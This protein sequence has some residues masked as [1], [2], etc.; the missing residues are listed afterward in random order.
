V[1]Y[2]YCPP[3]QLHRTLETKRVEGL[4][5]AGQINGTSGYEEAAAQGLVAGVNAARKLRGDDEWV[6]RRDQAYI[7]VLIDDLVV[8]GTPEPYRMFTSR[9]E[10][11]LLLRQDNADER[12]TP[13]ALEAGLACSERRALFQQKQQDRTALREHCETARD[14]GL[15]LGQW[16]LRPENTWRALPAEL[17]GDFAE[18]LWQAEETDRKYAGYIR[19]QEQ[20]IARSRRQEDRPFP[21]GIDF[22]EVRGLRAEARQKLAAVAPE[23]LGQAGRISGVTP[24]DVALLSVWLEKRRRLEEVAASATKGH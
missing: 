9:A 14:D 22:A 3:T 8:R 12:L 23:T 2:D 17:R 19:R 11:R 7:G 6:L 4:Y 13:L 21:A 20:Q 16:L 1:E 10:Y 18:E 15:F 24:A 5:F